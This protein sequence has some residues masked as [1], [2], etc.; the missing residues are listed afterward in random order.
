M[1]YLF[2]GRSHCEKG[3]GPCSGF[4]LLELLLVLFIAGIAISI[5]AVSVTRVYEKTVFKEEIKRLYTSLRQARDMAVLQRAVFAFSVDAGGGSY[6]LE[7]DGEAYGSPNVMPPDV[8]I[9]GDR[10]MFFPK[11]NSTGG[12]I[13]IDGPHERKYLIEVE[14]VTGRAK[15]RRL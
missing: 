12:S 2:R 14:A 4:T 9:K 1:R 10:I 15:V 7:K 5:V 8:R 13:E 3:H 11:G 6:R